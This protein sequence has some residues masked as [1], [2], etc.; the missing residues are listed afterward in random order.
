MFNWVDVVVLIVVGIYIWRGWREGFLRSAVDLIGLVLIVWAGMRF[1]A[2]L[3][4]WLEA[5][6]GIPTPYGLALGFL[7]AG[8]AATALFWVLAGLFLS[9]VPWAVHGNW[10]NRLAG[11]LPGLIA[12]ILAAT[13]LVT[14]VRASP[15]ERE[16]GDTI[17]A[18]P[19]G[20]TLSSAGQ[21][22]SQRLEPILGPAVA[23]AL[24]FFT[25]EPE[26]D[27]MIRLP[28][29]AASDTIRPADEEQM[30]SWVNDERRAA[31]LPPLVMDESL[32]QLAR[33][34]SQDMLRRG[35]FSHYT[36]DGQSPFD[37]MR[38]ADISFAAAG[39][40]LAEAPTLR[41]AHRGLMNSPGHRANILSPSFSRV[42]IG[43]IDGGDLGLMIS[44]EFTN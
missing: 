43:I 16:V 26:S 38:A 41:V 6:W 9:G 15:L 5:Q 12:G 2:P 40:N 8:I 22:V 19:L 21:S 13:V 24:S 20:S 11:L 34:H 31:G 1:Y 14:V 3:A 39:E 18:S 33:Q 27:A 4:S 32:R 37:R 7:L 28:H 23:E 30:L 25:V 29:T 10:L 35:Y 42:G 17:D 44:Q 36:P